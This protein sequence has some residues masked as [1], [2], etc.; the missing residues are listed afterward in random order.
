MRS[1]LFFYT[2]GSTNDEVCICMCMEKGKMEKLWAEL[3]GTI[4]IFLPD[5]CFP[6]YAFKNLRKGSW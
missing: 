4:K 6:G 1:W 3:P 5:Y 2:F